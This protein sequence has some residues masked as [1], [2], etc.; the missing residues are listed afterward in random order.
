MSKILISVG[1]LDK[2]AHIYADIIER[3]GAQPITAYASEY[4]DEYDGLLLAG[5]IDVNPKH[6]GEENV[7]ALNI[8][9]MRDAAELKLIKAFIDARKPIMGIC[10]GMQI[11]NVY[12][13][14]TLIQDLPCAIKHKQGVFHPVNTTTD[15]FISQLFGRSFIVN[16]YHH[17]AVKHLADCLITDLESNDGV[18]E[19]YHHKDLPIFA[20]QCHP[21]RMTGDSEQAK[22]AKSAGT[23]DAKPIFEYFLSL[24]K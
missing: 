2:N 23:P 8:D 3:C 20:L 6:Y 10:R 4:L 13:G 11:L 22:E 1:K 14:G 5:G 24:C 9:D 17:Q 21:E 15:N 7:S 19:G 18:L 12:F 16:S